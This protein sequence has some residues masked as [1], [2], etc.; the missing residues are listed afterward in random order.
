MRHILK[1]L[2]AI[3]KN[4]KGKTA[5]GMLKPNQTSHLTIVF[6]EITRLVQKSFGNR[7]LE[8]LFKRTKK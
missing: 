8:S 4:I 2:P 5:S 6:D 1:Y 7:S 3:I